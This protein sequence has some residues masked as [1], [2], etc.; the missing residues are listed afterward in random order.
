[1]IV[2]DETPDTPG[3]PQRR[4][5]ALP[6]DTDANGAIFGGWTVSLLSLAAYTLVAQR[7]DGWI[8]PVIIQAMRF[9]R[10]M[11]LENEVSCYCT[12]DYKRTARL[13]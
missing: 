5:I 2:A 1:V 4:T 8:I 9:L 7:P 11:S 10:P 12:S 13:S 3:G 6:R